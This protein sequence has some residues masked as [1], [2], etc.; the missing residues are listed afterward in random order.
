[1]QDTMR[2]LA[3]PPAHKQI[4]HSSGTVFEQGRGTA[5]GLCLG[6][7]L[8]SAW[9]KHATQRLVPQIRA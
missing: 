6:M 2:L 8:S 4:T 5:S 3:Q 1:M 7:S 9:R